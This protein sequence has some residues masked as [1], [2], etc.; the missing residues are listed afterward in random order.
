MTNANSY[1]AKK[2]E[3]LADRLESCVRQ[4]GQPDYSLGDLHRDCL[5]IA[6]DM[7][8]LPA[9]PVET[10]DMKVWRNDGP[11]T[12]VAL[13][14]RIVDSHEAFEEFKSD[15]DTTWTLAKSLLVVRGQLLA[16]LD[17]TNCEPAK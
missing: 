8:G 11:G 17:A 14:R 3:I 9:A 10:P 15:A 6:A 1:T 12:I 5:E 13:A 7:R 16:A 2:L 4:V